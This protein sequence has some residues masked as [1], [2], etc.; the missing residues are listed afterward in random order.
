MATDVPFPD[1]IIEVLK[2]RLGTIS[3]VSGVLVRPLEPTDPNGSVAVTFELWQPVQIEMG[4][5]R[6]FD[7]SLSDY[8]LHIEHM[9]KHAEREA[10]Y[11]QHRTVATKIRS[12]LY[13]DTDTQVA[14]R[15]LAYIDSL[16][17]ERLMKWSLEQ[18]FAANQTETV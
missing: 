5:G 15:Q 14:F 10:G 8:V 11:L 18:R 13:R 7:P 4:T 12:M 16:V 17:H 6:G 1:C 9:V 2:T 3:G